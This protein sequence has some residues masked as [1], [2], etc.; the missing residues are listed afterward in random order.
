[1]NTKASRNQLK[2]SYEK[3]LKVYRPLSETQKA[4][5]AG[6]L[7]GEGTISIQRQLWIANKTGS[8]FKATMEVANTSTDILNKIQL[9]T[10]LGFM[11]NHCGIK[12]KKLNPHHKVCWKLRFRQGEIKVLLP[13]IFP[14][15]Q[16]KRP[17]A[18][19]VMEYF[20]TVDELAGQPT[21]ETTSVYEPLRE[22]A[23]ELNRRG[24]KVVNG[25]ESPM[26]RV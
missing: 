18:E 10:G 4:Y 25:G 17:Q 6:F 1:M 12:R 16:L 21:L 2:K 15:L 7:D 14:Y 9:W 20:K 3:Y 26:P 8:R 24:L 22:R 23:M 13:E 5:I 19:L 11:D